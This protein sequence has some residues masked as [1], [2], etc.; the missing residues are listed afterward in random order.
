MQTVMVVTVDW[1][2][3]YRLPMDSVDTDGYIS[4]P[5]SLHAVLYG[6]RAQQAAVTGGVH[7]HALRLDVINSYVLVDTSSLDTE[8]FARPDNCNMG[9]YIDTHTTH[10]NFNEILDLEKVC[11]VKFMVVEC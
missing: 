10:F 11:H 2:N 9:K 4:N 6:R 7:G 5:S 1:V 3:H 8:C